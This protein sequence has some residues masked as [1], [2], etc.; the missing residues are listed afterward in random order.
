MNLLTRILEAVEGVDVAILLFIQEHLRFAFLTPF[1]KGITHLGDGGIFWVVLAL[2]LLAIPRTR[3]TGA[4]AL[5]SMGLTALIV[6]IVLKPTLARIRPYDLYSVQALIP[7]QVD[8]AFPSGHTASSFASA[9]I[10]LRTLR[11]PFGILAVV[12][13]A[14]IGLSRLYLGVHYPSDVLGGFLVALVV[15]TILLVL[16][17][18]DQADHSFGKSHGY[19]RSQGNGGRKRRRRG[20]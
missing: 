5:V 6:N 2:I 17:G 4:L 15:T 16:F 18:V 9:L 14:L 19:G 3:R 13:A 7:Y 1:V 12:L 11:R 10:Y 8:Y 20:A